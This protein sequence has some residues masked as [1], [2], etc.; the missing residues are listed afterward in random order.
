MPNPPAVW[1]VCHED[2][3]LCPWVRLRVK[4]RLRNEAMA[5]A[6]AADRDAGLAA[7]HC[8]PHTH[9]PVKFVAEKE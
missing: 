5:Q 2:G 1:L 7:N 9:H 3:S 4:G 8:I 6:E